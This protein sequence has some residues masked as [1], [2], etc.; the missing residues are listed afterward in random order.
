MRSA[1]PRATGRWAT[2]ASRTV[3]GAEGDRSADGRVLLALSGG[4]DSSVLAALCWPR[5][6]VSRLTCVFVDHGLMRKNE[7]DEVE[8]AFAKW[9]VQ[10]RPRRRRA[11]AS[12]AKLAGVTD[13][14]KKRH[15]IGAEFGYV[16]R[17]EAE[18]FGITEQ[19]F[20]AQGTIYPDVIESGKG[21]ADVIKSH[22][23]KLL[24]AEVVARFNGRS[25]AAESAV[26]GRGARSS[27]VSSACPS[28]WSCASRSPAPASPCA[29]SATSPSEKARHSC[30]RPTPSI[31]TRL[32][33]PARGQ[34]DQ[35]VFR[36]ADRLPQPS[37]SWAT[38]ALMTIL[39]ALRAVT[40]NDFMTAEW[41]RI[42]YEVLDRDLHPH[43]QRGPRHQP[44]RL[45][46]HEQAARDDRV[47]VSF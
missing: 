47:G 45:R 37:A 3:A 18:R 25:G 17:D 20:L 33:K 28:I 5:R 38:A 12:S 36:R 6:S 34:A 29:S 22:H 43:R 40:T 8:A 24:P 11:S 13:P 14:Q 23:N 35:P 41:A 9:D 44:H 10:L 26:Q 7:G 16:F 39:L 21:D 46:H 30:A 15:I 2:S 42:P 4:V 31:A 19:D 27:A 1:T 32:Q